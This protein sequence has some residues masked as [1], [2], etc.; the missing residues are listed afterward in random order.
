M[1]YGEICVSIVVG[2][3]VLVGGCGKEPSAQ[4][5][6]GRFEGSVYHNDYLGMT[7][8]IPSDWTVQDL[9]T[10]Q[11]LARAGE[12]MIAGNNERMQ[13]EMEEGQPRTVNLFNVF[14]HLP[15]SRVPHNPNLYAVAENIAHVPGIQTGGDYLYH[16]KQ[17]LQAGQIEFSFPREVYTEMLAGVEF[18]IMSVELEVPPTGKMMQEYFATVRKDHALMFTLSF[19]TEE[20]RAELRNIL[21]TMTLA[22]QAQQ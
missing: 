20:E 10:T 7:I 11:K 5:N 19:W 14:K 1:R 17:V 15:G 4:M 18:H 12:R 2:L 13:V 8:T 22:P 6:S 9:Q 21:N 16:A 3:C